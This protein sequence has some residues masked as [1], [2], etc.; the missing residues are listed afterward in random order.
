MGAVLFLFYFNEFPTPSITKGKK[1]LRPWN[2]TSSCWSA[3]YDDMTKKKPF[4]GKIIRKNK[5]A[6][7]IK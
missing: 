7:R 6:T 2:A 1:R 5:S 3:G 4:R